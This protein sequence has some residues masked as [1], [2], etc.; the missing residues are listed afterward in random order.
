[1]GQWGPKHGGK[2]AQG[3]CVGREET[4]PAEDGDKVAAPLCVHS[5]SVQTF[6]PLYLKSYKVICYF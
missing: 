6:P 2:K 5:T 1:M 4:S 3:V